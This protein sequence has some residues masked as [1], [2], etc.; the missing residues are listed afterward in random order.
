VKFAD[1]DVAFRRVPIGNVNP[2]DGLPT[3]VIIKNSSDGSGMSVVMKSILDRDSRDYAS[4][5]PSPTGFGLFAWNLGRLRELQFD[6][7]FAPLES[8][9]GHANLVHLLSLIEPER[10]WTRT[11]RRALVAEGWWEIEPSA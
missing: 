3:S 9:P 2:E 6:V 1:A 10:P 7:V 8:E 4:L 11:L 5:F